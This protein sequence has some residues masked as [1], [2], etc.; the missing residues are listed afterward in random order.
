VKRRRRSNSQRSLSIVLAA[1][2]SSRFRARRALAGGAAFHD[3]RDRGGAIEFGSV[4]SVLLDSA[5]VLVVVDDRN[6]TVNEFD[7]T[8]A[9]VRQIGRDGRRTR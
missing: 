8:G 1:S 5:G 3:W 2:Q 4:R 6:R 9:F 7:S